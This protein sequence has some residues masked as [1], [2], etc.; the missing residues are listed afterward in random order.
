MEIYKYYPET[1]TER[2]T[3]IDLKDSSA[4]KDIVIVMTGVGSSVSYGRDEEGIYGY[5][6]TSNYKGTQRE[7]SDGSRS[8]L[9]HRIKERFKNAQEKMIKTYGEVQIND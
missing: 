2:V 8:F 9:K 3:N 4:I 7:L 1:E 6:D 5:F